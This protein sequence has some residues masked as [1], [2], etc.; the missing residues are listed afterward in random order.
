[1]LFFVKSSSLWVIEQS[2]YKEKVFF[3]EYWLKGTK[4]LKFE[5]LEGIN[6]FYFSSNFGIFVPLIDCDKNLR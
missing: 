6:N 1:M 4:I 2:L 3:K 5:Y